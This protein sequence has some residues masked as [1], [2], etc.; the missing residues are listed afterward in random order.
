MTDLAQ[1]D[2]LLAAQEKG[3]EV[4]ILHPKTGE[5]LGIQ[6]I[7]AG[8]ESERQTKVRNRVVNDRINRNRNRKTT[9]AELDAD[10]LKLSAAAIISWSGV[11][12]GE[13]PLELTMANAEMLLKKYP[14][15]REQVDV[16]VGDRAAFIKD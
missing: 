15:I 2:G 1:F 8:P 5:D 4:N 16:V 14:W 6:I 12:I 9:A 7:V 11:N 10:A 3:V 13:T